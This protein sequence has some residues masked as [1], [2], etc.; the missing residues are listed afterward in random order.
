MKRVDAYLRKWGYHYVNNVFSGTYF[1][2]KFFLSG[3]D[4]WQKKR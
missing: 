3:K 2:G 4:L 1:N